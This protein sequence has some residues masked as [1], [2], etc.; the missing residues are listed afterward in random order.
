MTTKKA[1]SERGRAAMKVTL[2]QATAREV[3]AIAKSRMAT[4]EK[5]T[6]D[7]GPGPWTSTVTEKGVLFNMR[8]GRVYVAREGRTI[9]GSLLLTTKKPWAI[10][11]SY[12][13]KSERP[14][15][16]LAMAVAP[17]RQRRGIGRAMLEDVKR[18]VKAWPGDAIRL[19]AYDLPGGAGEFYAKCGYREMG[20]V[21]YRGAPLIYYEFLLS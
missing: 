18:I 20:R 13:S 8:N 5:L 12:F 21:I 15:Y 19:D 2:K 7:F 11:R 3:A 9:I 14:L 17:D 6:R 10:D 1:V 4:N 16:L